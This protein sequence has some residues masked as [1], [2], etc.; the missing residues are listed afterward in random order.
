ML[1]YNAYF[2]ALNAAQVE[3]HAQ[4]V[5]LLYCTLWT[6]APTFANCVFMLFRTVT[7]AIRLEPSAINAYRL[8]FMSMQAKTAFHATLLVWTVW[9]AQ[10]VCLALMTLSLTYLLRKSVFYAV[11]LCRDAT[12]V[13]SKMFALPVQQQEELIFSLTRQ[14]F[15]CIKIKTLV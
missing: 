4:N 15:F 1:V 9:A 10:N 2:L 8:S 6:L 13:F 14:V 12:L 3:Q 11:V 7:L 5:R